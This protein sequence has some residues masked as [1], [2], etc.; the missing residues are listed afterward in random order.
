MIGIFNNKR[1]NKENLAL[2][3]SG[4]F[5]AGMTNVLTVL[6]FFAFASNVTGHFAVLAEELAKGNWYQAGVGLLWVTSF[7]LGSYNSNLILNYAI[8]SGRSLFRVLPL[9][10]VAISLFITAIYVEFY[11]Q[12]QL[13]ETE[14]LVA[15]LLFAMGSLNGFSSGI[16]DGKVKTTH[17]TG[18]TTDLGVLIGKLSYKDNRENKALKKSLKLLLTILTSYMTGGVVAGLLFLT[19]G[20]NVMFL[21]VLFILSIV[22]TDIL[23]HKY[24]SI[25]QYLR[26]LNISQLRTYIGKKD[27]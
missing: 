6:V 14:L 26:L 13:R 5:L 27:Y 15:A 17:L 20:I 19:T 10:V 25:T 8:K 21:V 1:G 23:Y 3:L 7:F 18:L 9:I 4:G 12:E 16:S 2:G 22:L 24:E 11:Y